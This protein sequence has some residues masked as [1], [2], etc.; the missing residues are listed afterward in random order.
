[1]KTAILAITDGGCLLGK[2]LAAD[3]DK[4]VFLNCRGALKETLLK[5]WDEYDGLI[6]IM[7]TGIVVRVLAEKFKDK[8]S[9]PAIVICDERGKFAI[10]LL[11]GHLGGGNELAVQVA[12][13]ID[14]QPVITTSSDV[15]G[16]VPLDIW[17]RELGLIITDTDKGKFT[18][19][20]GKLVNNGMI[21]LYSDYR[22]DNLPEEISILSN[23]KVADL[24]ISYRTGLSVSGLQLYP[25]KL[26]A[27]IGCNRNTPADEI[28]NA[29]NEAC[30]TS[31][32]SIL[33]IKSLA[34]I[35]LKQDEQG[36]LN[37]AGQSDYRIDFFNRDQLN[38]VD[39][40]SVSALVLKATGAK[41]VAEPAAI[42]AAN[43]GKLIVKKMKWANVTVAIAE[44]A[45][46]PVRECISESPVP[47]SKSTLST[48]P[49]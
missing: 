10:S 36:L 43:G 48:F 8:R 40:V 24:V 37:F 44:A 9:D 31:Q 45:Q 42:L 2:R 27:G 49:I 29:L 7:A 35:D 38:A 21:T 30:E 26:I 1:M 47:R 15:Q 17:A 46:E 32:I 28:K 19:I 25:Q 11:G 20:T 22:I 23:P 39:N 5:A 12:K 34:S 41:G 18:K 33:S 4:A 6:C 14:A 16:L 3:L 13:I